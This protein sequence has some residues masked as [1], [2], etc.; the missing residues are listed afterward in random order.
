MG[1]FIRIGRSRMA[2]APPQEFV[3]GEFLVR[4]YASPIALPGVEGWI[5]AW[6]IYRRNEYPGAQPLRIGDTELEHSEA[7]ALGMAKAIASAVV[8]AL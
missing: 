8:A 1:P 7:T 6:S 2:L 5:G 3:V 4:V